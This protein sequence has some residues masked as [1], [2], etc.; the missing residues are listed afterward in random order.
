MLE[1]IAFSI[2][3]FARNLQLTIGACYAT[4]MVLEHCTCQLYA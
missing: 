3:T 4:N 1:E 2:V